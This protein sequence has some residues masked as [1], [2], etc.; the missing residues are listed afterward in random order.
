MPN[1]EDIVVEEEPGLSAE[2]LWQFYVENNCCETRYPME[3]ATSVLQ[4]SAAVVTARDHGKLVGVARAVSDGLSAQVMELSVALSH[5]GPGARNGTGALVEDD[6]FDVGKR[7]G[8]TLVEVLHSQ[9][10]DWIEMV[11]WKTELETYSDAGFQVKE[12][13]RAVFVDTRPLWKKA[14]QRSRRGDAG[15]RAPHRWRWLQEMMGVTLHEATDQDLPIAKN[16]VPYYIYDMSEY[17]GWACTPDGRFDGCDELPSYWEEPGKHAF[18]LRAGKEIAGFA[19][20]RG[21]HEEEDIDF[22]IGEFFVLRKFRGR[23][24]GERIARQLFDR[25]RGRWKVAQLARNTPALA[26]WRKVIGRYTSG[27]F[28]ECE[29]DSPWGEWNVILFRNDIS[30]RSGP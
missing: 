2:D 16:L 21:N 9:G 5:Q 24:V 11:A 3:R 6:K 1:K 8:Q 12:E 27:E 15:D 28:H 30:S 22:S 18:M 13:D 4:N 7:L 20:V 10:V 26:F 25:F 14:G 23:G 17:L 29:E 19:L